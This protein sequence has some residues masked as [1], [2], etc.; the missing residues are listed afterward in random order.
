M[1]YLLVVG[2]HS[3]VYRKKPQARV[4]FN[5]QLIDE[6]NIDTCLEKKSFYPAGTL[7]PFT[8]ELRKKQSINKFCR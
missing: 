6:F 2:F 1:K 8:W 4:F 3:N 5:D 7:T